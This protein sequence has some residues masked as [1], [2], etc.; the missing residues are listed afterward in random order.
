MGD[1]KKHEL[2]FRE[3][4]PN[5]EEWPDTPSWFLI[6]VHDTVCLKKFVS[7]PV[8]FAPFSVRHGVTLQHRRPCGF[9]KACLGRYFAQQLF[10][11]RV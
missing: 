9:P 10:C 1:W 8:S 4:Y 6:S 3:W 2:W 11:K 7:R 5:F